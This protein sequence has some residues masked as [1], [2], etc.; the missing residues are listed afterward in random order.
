VIPSSHAQLIQF[1]E[2]WTHDRT[3]QWGCAECGRIFWTSEPPQH[4]PFEHCDH[5]WVDARNEIVLSGEVCLK[6]RA[7]RGGNQE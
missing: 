4:C 7:I 5:E 1:D 3:Q 2:S 6:C